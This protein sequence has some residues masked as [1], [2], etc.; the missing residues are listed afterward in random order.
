LK[1]YGDA[2][3][4][5]QRALGRI[6]GLN[7]RVLQAKTHALLG[8]IFAETGKAPDARRQ[9]TQALRMFEELRKEA[10]T[11]RVLARSDLAA[12]L[13]EAQRGS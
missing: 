12:A 13:K 1:Q 4:D 10:G 9:R 8:T 7:L 2:Q 6:E 11:D 3:R 5:L